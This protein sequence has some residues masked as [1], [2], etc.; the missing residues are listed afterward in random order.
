MTGEPATFQLG[1][2]AAV[3][4]DPS[5]VWRTGWS[6]PAEPSARLTPLTSMAKSWHV[7]YGGVRGRM[8]RLGTTAVPT[9]R[10]RL[11]C[12][13][14]RRVRHAT[15]ESLKLAVTSFP[16]PGTVGDPPHL[17]PH[18]WGFAVRRWPSRC[19]RRRVGSG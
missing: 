14:G 16:P 3:R 18:R 9:I 1:T 7:P 12:V 4:T 5:R 19:E 6:M 8:N 15:E 13:A 10:A 11:G 17:R 2:V